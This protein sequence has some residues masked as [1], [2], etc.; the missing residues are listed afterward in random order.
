VKFTG[1]DKIEIALGF[2]LA[3]FGHDMIW[4]W[5]AW[6]FPIPTAITKQACKSTDNAIYHP[7][8]R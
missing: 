4:L 2:G 3:K 1:L 6:G 7:F 5:A 8:D